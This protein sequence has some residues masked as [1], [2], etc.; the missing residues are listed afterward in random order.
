VVSKARDYGVNVTVRLPPAIVA[1]VD[2]LVEAGF[3]KNRCD[4]I[5]EAVR[6]LLVKYY[7]LDTEKPVEGVR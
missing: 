1:R 3:F 6:Q 7:S 2:R 5:R 4:L